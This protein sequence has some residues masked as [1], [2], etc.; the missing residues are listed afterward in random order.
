MTEIEKLAPEAQAAYWKARALAAEKVIEDSALSHYRSHLGSDEE[1]ASVRKFV[2]SEIADRMVFTLKSRGGYME[3]G[4]QRRYFEAF[5][6]PWGPLGKTDIEFTLRGNGSIT[7]PALTPLH[8]RFP[9]VGLDW[10][11]VAV[12]FAESAC[13]AC[14]AQGWIEGPGPGSRYVRP[15]VVC[16]KCGGNGVLRF[17]AQARPTYPHQW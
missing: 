5:G 15:P 2:E 7:S 16:E 3:D 17:N 14:K 1:R 11:I 12:P 9:A 6:A 8:R 10:V 4:F 13:D